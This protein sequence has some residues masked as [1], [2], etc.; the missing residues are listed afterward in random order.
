MH[1]RAAELQTLSNHSLAHVKQNF[2]PAKLSVAASAVATA[3]IFAI[4]LPTSGCVT[5]PR[6]ES[7]AS[8]TSFDATSIEPKREHHSRVNIN[9]AGAKEL[10]ALPGIGR[11]IAERILEHRGMYGRFRRP[12][13]LMMVRG[14]SDKKFRELR[15]LVAAD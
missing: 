14:I 13:H 12:E 9:S 1:T 6:Q 5:L 11:A 3:L 15:G 4:L 8:T 10:E 7:A 2:P